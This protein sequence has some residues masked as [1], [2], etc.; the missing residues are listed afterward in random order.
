MINLQNL[1]QTTPEI[2]PKRLEMVRVAI[3]SL[4]KV[5][6]LASRDLWDGP[7]MGVRTRK[8]A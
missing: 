8:A 3:P 2:L 5:G 1:T 6:F 7:R 4:T